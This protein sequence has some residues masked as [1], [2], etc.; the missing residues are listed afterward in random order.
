MYPMRK[1]TKAEQRE[2]VKCLIRLAWG[3]WDQEVYQRAR[4]LVVEVLEL[5]DERPLDRQKRKEALNKF[6][7]DGGIY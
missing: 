3:N 1:M 6:L 2:A 5:P 7:A 4:K